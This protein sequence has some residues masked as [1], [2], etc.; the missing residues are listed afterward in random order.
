V[1]D[2]SKYEIE[3]PRHLGEIKRVGALMHVRQIDPVEPQSLSPA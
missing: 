1:S 2:V 3:W